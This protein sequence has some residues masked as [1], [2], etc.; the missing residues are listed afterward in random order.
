MHNV[1]DMLDREWARLSV[2]RAAAR[3]LAPVCRLGGAPVRTL[4]DL[5]RHVRTAGPAE[6]D[7]ILLALVTRVVDRDDDLA[8]RVLLQLLLP[9][10]RNLAR[11]WWALGDHDE[12]AAA[13]VGAVYDRI[14]T[15]PLARR[16][17]RV[18][19]NVLMDAARQLRRSVPRLATVVTADP[20]VHDRRADEGTAH[21]AVELADALADAVDAGIIDRRDAQIIAQSRIG[22]RRIADL[23]AHH[24]IGSRTLWDRRHRAEKAL[25]GAAARPA[26]A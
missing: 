10:T 2:D 17:G 22:G 19:A 8:A 15:Y 14:R 24:R 23:A 18:A 21:A 7:A 11:R 6:A 3:R 13:A 4:G 26:C 20:V 5:E 1:F 9:G 12:R 25:A 16:P